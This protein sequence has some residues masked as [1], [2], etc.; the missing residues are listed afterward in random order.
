MWLE[1][2][3]IGF[4]LYALFGDYMSAAAEML[5][6]KAREKEIANDE[7]EFGPHEN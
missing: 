4:T 1:L 6:E 5:H 7:K 3:I 2:M